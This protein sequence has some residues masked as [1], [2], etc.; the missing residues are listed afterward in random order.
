MVGSFNKQTGI[1][2]KQFTLIPVLL[3]A[4]IACSTETR[5]LFFDIKP[6]MAEELASKP[7][8]S[9]EI[10][11]SQTKDKNLSLVPVCFHF[12]VWMKTFPH[13]Q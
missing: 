5:Q 6:P 1:R 9:P 4:V 13:R 7:S 12:Q 11:E 2:V 10:Q 3:L 8:E